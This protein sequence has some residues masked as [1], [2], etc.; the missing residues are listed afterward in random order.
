MNTIYIIN[1]LNY[2]SMS[3][4]YFKSVLAVAICLFVNAMTFAQTTNV[5][6]GGIQNSQGAIWRNGAVEL[7]DNTEQVYFIV[8]DGQDEYVAGRNTEYVPVVWK[9]GEELYKLS[10]F[11]YEDRSISS[12]AIHN[13]N[14]YVTTIDLTPTYDFVARVWINGV[15]SEDYPDAA[16]INGIFIDGDD[17]YVAGRTELQGVIWKNAEPLYTCYSAGT[18]LFCDVIV[19]DGDVYY[20]GGD[21]GGGAGKT[22]AMKSQNEIPSH[23][24]HDRDFGVK[25]W[26][27]GEELYFIGEEV[28]SG[29]IGVLD[30]TVYVSGQAPSADYMKYLSY[31]W[32]NGE[33][34]AL[35]DV[36]S[37]PGT[38]CIH[39]GDI[40]LSGF[41][42]NFPELD[43]YVWVNGEMTILTQGGYNMGNC[44]F[45][46]DED[47]NVEEGNDNVTIYPNPANEFISIEGVAFEEASL[48]NSLGQLI[49]TTKANKIDVSSLES[50]L[51]LLKLDAKV[52]KSILIQH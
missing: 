46:A 25:V 17:V 19:V 33:P 45:V 16:E 49:L 39:N 15:P 11:E 10:E 26:K 8:V 1:S 44:I 41:V 47:T 29:R 21:F 37:G 28:Y 32:T 18:A 27:N 52:A 9:N 51:Y 13:G 3:K 22:A 40:Y 30:G 34:M 23:Q 48:Y 20:L 14:V 4:F 7:L 31:L 5:Y 43:A 38:M 50:G 12:M 24:N 42:G 35:S 2:H 6:V 36:W